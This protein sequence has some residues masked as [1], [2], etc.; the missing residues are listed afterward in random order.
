MIGMRYLKGVVTLRLDV[1]LC[2][3][4]RVCTQVCP[5]DAIVNK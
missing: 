1:E 5:K 2:N 3:G 4:C